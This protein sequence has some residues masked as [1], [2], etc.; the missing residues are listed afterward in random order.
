MRDLRIAAA[1]FEYRDGDK[2]YNL[3][4]IREL[5]RQAVERGAEV[6]SFPECCI[7]SY[8]FVQTFSREQLA[9]LAEP[10]PD[11][12]STRE[13]IRI[14]AEFQVPVLAGLFE[15]DGDRIHN[16]Y[17]CVTADGLVARHRKL[18]TFVSR[19]L[20]PGNEYTV[21]DLLGCRCGCV[22]RRDIQPAQT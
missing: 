1:Q 14:A 21:F 20:T 15:R 13:L 11:G 9:K 2:A 10:V 3:M 8:S 12:P 6:V 17:I 5:T 18:H 16:T 19:H 4:R 22:C 7:S